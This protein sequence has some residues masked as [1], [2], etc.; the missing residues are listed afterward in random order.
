MLPQN[1]LITDSKELLI[2]YSYSVY[3]AEDAYLVSVGNRIDHDSRF[4]PNGPCTDIVNYIK[5]P[6][7]GIVRLAKM[8]YIKHPLN[9]GT[10]IS[11]ILDVQVY[12]TNTMETYT[13]K[14]TALIDADKHPEALEAA[15]D[16]RDAFRSFWKLS[17]GAHTTILDNWD[18]IA[19]DTA[20]NFIKV[21]IPTALG[22]TTW[23]RGTVTKVYD[24]TFEEGI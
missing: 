12:D 2:R 7:D 9:S 24:R 6:K 4:N 23:D 11:L 8:S 17:I 20:I 10:K 3:P 1:G 15:N 16:F 14:V 19:V 18:D 5:V 13:R 22:S 21:K